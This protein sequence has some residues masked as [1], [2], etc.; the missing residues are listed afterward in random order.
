MDG[1]L[2]NSYIKLLNKEANK[3][4]RGEK[5]RNANREIKA[6]SECYRPSANEDSRNG[7]HEPHTTGL[8]SLHSRR[9]YGSPVVFGIL[10]REVFI[11]GHKPEI[12]RDLFKKND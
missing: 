2:P 6:N 1:R 5:R 10:R 4:K 12:R 8:E 9:V 7:N 3:N 11:Q